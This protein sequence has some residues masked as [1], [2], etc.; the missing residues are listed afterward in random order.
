MLFAPF[1]SVQRNQFTV[2][3]AALGGSKE[4]GIL[5]TRN[6]GLGLGYRFSCFPNQQVYKLLAPA[7]NDRRHFSQKERSGCWRQFAVRLKSF[8]RGLKGLLH[9]LWTRIEIA[10]HRLVSIRVFDFGCLRGTYP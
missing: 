5:G 9:L 4:K 8:M 10:A 2:R 3:L 7:L 1:A 6:F